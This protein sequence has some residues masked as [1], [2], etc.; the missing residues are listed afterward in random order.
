ME[1]LSIL[2]I[3]FRGVKPPTRIVGEIKG[4]EIHELLESPTRAKMAT[5]A[6]RKMF[7][8]VLD[9]FSTVS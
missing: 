9:R 4:F 3:F 2:T 1:E 8:L 7:L 5:L 6:S